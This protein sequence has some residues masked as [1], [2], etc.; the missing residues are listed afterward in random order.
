M[1]Q[2]EVS[3][4]TGF[5]QAKISRI[6]SSIVHLSVIDVIILSEVYGISREYAFNGERRMR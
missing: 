5:S 1:S 3:E 2:R 4:G 6:E